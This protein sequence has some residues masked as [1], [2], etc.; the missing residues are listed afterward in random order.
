MTDG[1]R[2]RAH[3]EA[4]K[5]TKAMRRVAERDHG[6]DR[7]GRDT[8]SAATLAAMEKRGLVVRKTRKGRMNPAPEGVETRR[9]WHWTA[10]GR[11]TVR[12]LADTDEL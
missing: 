11:A 5:L 6:G 12:A 4:G 8:P 1:H 2:A 7:I 10:L 3:A 9:H